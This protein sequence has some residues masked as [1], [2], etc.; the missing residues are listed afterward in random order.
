MMAKYILITGAREYPD[1]ELVKIQIWGEY[2]PDEPTYLINGQAR[3][4]DKCAA[5]YAIGAGISTID[6]PAEWTKYGKAAG[7]IRNQQMVDFARQKK[8][9][10]N[11]VVCLAFPLKPR[12]PHSGTWDC[13]DR[14]R[15][16]GLWCKEFAQ[17]AVGID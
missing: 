12:N 15:R 7:P 9:S 17:E 11:E 2:D 6:M 16:A 5:E 10:G 14:I 1:L 3:G 4:V 8:E 13:I